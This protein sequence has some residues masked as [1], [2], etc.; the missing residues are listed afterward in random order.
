VSEALFTRPVRRSR[1]DRISETRQSLLRSA[2]RVIATHGYAGAS[3]ARVTEMA[4]VSQGSF[5][6]YFPSRQALFNAV[7][8]EAGQD[9]LD[10]IRDRVKRS[11]SF[12]DVELKGLRALFA[13]LDLNPHFMCVLD[14]AE[15][16]VPEAHRQHTM[17]VQRRYT[18]A[19]ARARDSG[20]IGCF[21]DR[22]LDLLC[23][24]FCGSRNYLAF[25]YRP[26]V[27]GE[28]L[29]PQAALRAYERLICS[30]LRPLSGAPADEV[31][32]GVPDGVPAGRASAPS[33]RRDALLRAAVQVIGR[34]GYENASIADIAAAAQVAVGTVYLYFHSRQDLLNRVLDYM[35]RDLFRLLERRTADARTAAD[36]ELRAFDAYF[37]FCETAPAFLRVE[38][39]AKVWAREAHARHIVQL[40][41]HYT[42]AMRRGVAAGG[43]ALDWT[44]DE[45]EA[46]VYA[47]LGARHYVAETFLWEKRNVRLPRWIAGTWRRV[48]ED[49]LVVG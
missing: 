18:P 34:Q 37:E 14:D 3:I 10:F 40:V 44:P 12:V 4:G 16:A 6:T 39:E 21:S 26:A 42:A 23:R 8:P 47:L 5:Y 17:N 15:V 38:R 1:A 27:M 43:E 46:L 45:L 33:D 32:N 22:E 13:Y 28:G 7:L 30:G 9:M 24:M 19:F 35:R 49:G 20:E 36:Y 25:R 29:L 48:I 41:A 11:V 31:P 2:A